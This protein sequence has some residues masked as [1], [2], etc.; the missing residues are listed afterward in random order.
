MENAELNVMVG[1]LKAQISVLEARIKKLGRP[2]ES[3]KLAD[4][5]G[6]LAEFGPTTKEEIDA[7][8]FR[9]KEPLL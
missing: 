6:I 5:Y 9:L 3:R 8:K 1:S 4:F 7:V 2:M